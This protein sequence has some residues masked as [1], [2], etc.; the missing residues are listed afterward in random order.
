MERNMQIILFFYLKRTQIQW[1]DKIGNFL[2]SFSFQQKY[3]SHWPPMVPEILPYVLLLMEP[4]T[5]Q[6][7]TDTMMVFT[8]LNFL[9]GVAH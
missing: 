1:V 4:Q 6:E 5:Q 2:K 8:A 3:S 9:G 7:H